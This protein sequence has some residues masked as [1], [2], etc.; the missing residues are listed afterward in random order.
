MIDGILFPSQLAIVNT[1]SIIAPQTYIEVVSNKSGKF[2][3]GDVAEV[4]LEDPI[5]LSTVTVMVPVLAFD[6]SNLFIDW[7]VVSDGMFGTVQKA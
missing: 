3:V 5:S 2:C 6:G 7:S 1:L 4:Q